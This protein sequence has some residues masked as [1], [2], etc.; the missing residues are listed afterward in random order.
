M[1]ESSK[2]APRF[3]EDAGPAGLFPGGDLASFRVALDGFDGPLDM[4]LALARDQ[5]VDLTRISILALAEQYLAFIEQARALR[6]EVAAD[7]LVMAAWLA[8]L[9]SRLLLPPPAEE[10]GSEPSA[11]EMA[12]ALTFQLQRLQAMQDAGRTLMARAR[13]GVEVFRRGQPELFITSV[14]GAWQNNLQELIQA[15]ANTQTRAED[16]TLHVEP[17]RFWTVQDALE[18]LAGMIGAL[19]DWAELSRFLPE[20]VEPGLPTRA[21]LAA[22]LLATLEMAKA[23][24]IALRQEQAFGPIWVKRSKAGA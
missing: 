18:R 20:R 21:A 15:Y 3:E 11:E 8:Y 6:L 10:A 22:T 13:L 19:P 24:N 1:S 14:P 9:K 17:V 4:L 2:A 5:K 7:W 16:S 12:A 23:G